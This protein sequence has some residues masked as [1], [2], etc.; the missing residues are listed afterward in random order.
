MFSVL[1]I[2]GVPR[3]INYKSLKEDLL[4]ITGVVAAHGV[5]IWSLTTTQPALAAHLTVGKLTA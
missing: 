2:A 1:F 4:S 3:D 5:H